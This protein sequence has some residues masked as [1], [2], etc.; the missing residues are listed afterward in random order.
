MS[1]IQLDTPADIHT[2]IKREQLDREAK[3]E[4]VNLKDLYYEVLRI[5]LESLEKQKAPAK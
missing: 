4:K 5:G 2:K 1:K 3:G